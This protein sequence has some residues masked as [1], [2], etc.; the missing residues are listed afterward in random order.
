MNPHGLA[1]GYWVGGGWPPGA[2]SR[3]PT[4]AAA[5]D[6]QGNRRHIGSGA[7][8]RLSSTPY[9]V[10]GGGPKLP[11]GAGPVVNLAEAMARDAGLVV[12]LRNNYAQDPEDQSSRGFGARASFG[13]RSA[14]VP[15]TASRPPGPDGQGQVSHFDL[16][17][18]G[19]WRWCAAPFSALYGNGSGGVI[20]RCQQRAGRARG[21]AI[22]R[23]A[24]SAGCCHCAWASM[25]A[26]RRS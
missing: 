22:W 19:A 25:P 26:R 9:A 11:R 14:P 5:E 8:Q 20:A 23:H 12:N 21:V 6:P 17:G 4:Q 15:A 18:A 10:G 1:A 7:E 24:G 16:A 3:G 2:T 13:V